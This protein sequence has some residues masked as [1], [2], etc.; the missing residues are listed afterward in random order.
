MSSESH[1]QALVLPRLTR[2]SPILLEVFLFG[3]DLLHAHRSP[4]AVASPAVVPTLLLLWKHLLA[5]CPQKHQRAGCVQLAAPRLQLLL[6]LWD[7]LHKPFPV[8]QELQVGVTFPKPGSNL[9]AGKTDGKTILPW[10]VSLQGCLCRAVNV[11]TLDDT[12]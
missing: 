3:L 5:V 4:F 12:G 11:P 8:A 10:T 6:V 9:G 2:K 7:V 1:T